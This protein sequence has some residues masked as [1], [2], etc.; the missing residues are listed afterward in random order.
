MNS[1]K[2]FEGAFYITDISNGL[3]EINKLKPKKYWK[4]N[5][6]DILCNIEDSSLNIN[7]IYNE[8]GSPVSYC[9]SLGVYIEGEYK[10][11]F[12]ASDIYNNE[13]IDISHVIKKVYPIRVWS[14]N[15]DGSLCLPTVK[16]ENLLP[17]HTNAIQE[18]HKLVLS[19]QNEVSELKYE[20]V[21]LKNQEPEAEPEQ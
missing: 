18:L 19:L 20:L 7:N 3:E 21:S 14:N 10:S 16:V 12:L 8:G 15:L 13:F 6:S 4:A 5:Y 1:N 2:Y 11:G 17:Y 9:D